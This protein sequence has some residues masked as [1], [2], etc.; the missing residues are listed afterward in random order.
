MVDGAGD[1]Q[2]R[3]RIAAVAHLC[4]WFDVGQRALQDQRIVA[5]ERDRRRRRVL[6]ADRALHHRLVAGGIGAG[7]GDRVVAG[8]RVI[9]GTADLERRRRITLVGDAGPRLDVGQRALQ[10]ERAVPRQ[11]HDRIRDIDD[12]HR[13]RRRRRQARRVRHRVGHGVVARGCHVDRTDGDDAARQVAV[14]GVEHR[15][16]GIVVSQR[17]L[18]RDRGLADDRQHR[19][20]RVDNT[21]RARCLGRVAVG[22]RRRVNDGVITRCPDIDRGGVDV[23]DGGRVTSVDDRCPGLDVAV[24]AALQDQGIVAREG[25]HRRC[26]VDDLDRDRIGL[27]LELTVADD[28]CDDMAALVQPHR[29]RHTRGRAE[30]TGPGVGQRIV[31][32]VAGAGAVE[33]DRGARCLTVREHALHRLV[34]TGIGH[35]RPVHVL[36]GLHAGR[37]LRGANAPEGCRGRDAGAHREAAGHRHD[38][39][40]L[41]GRVRGHLRRAQQLGSFAETARVAVVAGEEVDGEGAQGQSVDLHDDLP[42]QGAGPLDDG[43]VEQAVG[44]GVAVPGVVGRH[45]VSLQIDAQLGVRVDLVRQDRVPFAGENPHAGASAVGDGI[46]CTRFR[47]AERVADGVRD[48]DAAPAIPEGRATD[49]DAD[50][51]ALHGV[52]RGAGAVDDDAVVAVAGDEVA[53]ADRRAADLVVARA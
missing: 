21:H 1:L 15:G 23:Q 36:D 24:D 32:R 30:G 14:A 13:A 49:V 44:P 39:A 45:P 51:V 53:G 27:R 35:R 40:A 43:E 41:P 48:D 8:C 20:R 16:T 34:G 29:R 11:R 18:Y 50:G 37:E 3:R 42:I 10:D 7:V 38:G 22:V 17:T 46:S 12:A 4:A 31:V 33:R 26:R 5:V 6:H 2:Y 28:Q 25:D 9:D 47:P 52:A 19:R